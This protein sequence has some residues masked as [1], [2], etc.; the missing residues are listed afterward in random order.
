[1]SV[2]CRLVVRF[3]A[4][5]TTSCSAGADPAE[6]PA[7]GSCGPPAEAPAGN[8]VAA[9]AAPP[10]TRARLTNALIFIGSPALFWTASDGAA[11]QSVSARQTLV[12]F[13]HTRNNILA[14]ERGRVVGMG[15]SMAGLLSQRVAIVTGAGRGLGR[16]HALAL[17][18]SGARVVINDLDAASADQVC[19]EIVRSGGEALGSTANVQYP[20]EV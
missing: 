12:K 7:D 19:E 3:S 17:A 14:A 13:I 1:M 16:A 2:C 18:R 9:D 5:T 8:T 15:V 4:V 10:I 6:P 11:G 20:G